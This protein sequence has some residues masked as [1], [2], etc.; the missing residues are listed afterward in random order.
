MRAFSLKGENEMAGIFSD[1]GKNAMLNALGAVAV[2]VSIHTDDPGTNGA[3]EV[4]GGSP[5]YARK[6]M[7]WGAAS[8]GVMAHSAAPTFDVPAG[9]T[10]KYVGMFSA[11]TA[12]TF[13][14]ADDVT[15]EVY[16]A[17]GTYTLTG[18]D[19]DLNA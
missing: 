6:A 7:T 10:V 19:L 18:I 12:G 3:N 9:T 17:Q 4:T 13:Y 16:G 15:N 1:L 2:F 8:G 5:A 11:S 14:G